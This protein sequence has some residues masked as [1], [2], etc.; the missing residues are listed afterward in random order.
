MLFS[1]NTFVTANNLMLLSHICYL[2][3]FYFLYIIRRPTWSIWCFVVGDTLSTDAPR[4]V[5]TRGALERPLFDPS[6]A[7]T[8]LRNPALHLST[9][10]SVSQATLSTTQ[11]SLPITGASLPL[12]RHWDIPH[13]L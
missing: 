12:L 5:G 2:I 3:N 6:E 11:R 1:R 4:L 9:Y 8:R 10:A 7:Q 13:Q